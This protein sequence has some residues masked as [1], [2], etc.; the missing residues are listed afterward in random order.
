M[1][2]RVPHDVLTKETTELFLYTKGDYLHIIQ[3]LKVLNRKAM[4]VSQKENLI[5][6]NSSSKCN[7][8]RII[9]VI[10]FLYSVHIRMIFL[11]CKTI[12]LLYSQ[13]IPGN[14][15]MLRVIL[16]QMY[17]PNTYTTKDFR[18]QIG[19]FMAREVHHFYP[20]MSDYLNKK[21]LTYV[22]Y[23]TGVGLGDISPDKFMILAI[24]RMCNISISTLK[25]YVQCHVELIPQIKKSEYSYHWKWERIR[26]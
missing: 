24:S 1:E 5:D 8:N 7:R 23:V 3:K 11:Y 12:S 20:Q 21:G 10:Y 4:P 22:A 16:K 26:Q 9:W 15:S 13:I 17:M 6:S 19:A 14:S 2:L 18:S 25:P